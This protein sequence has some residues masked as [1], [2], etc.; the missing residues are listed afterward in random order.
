MAGRHGN[1]GVVSRILP[2][3]DMPHLPD[4]TPVDIILNPLGV[5]SRMNIGQIMETHLGVV[6]HDLELQLREPDFRRGDRIGNPDL[7]GADDAA[8]SPQALTEY[9]DED[10]ALPMPP[11]TNEIT[12]DQLVRD[13]RRLSLK[14]LE[15][16]AKDLNAQYREHLREA[17]RMVIADM[18][19]EH[20]FGQVTV[21]DVPLED[22]QDASEEQR[23]AWMADELH[24]RVNESSWIR[25]DN[26]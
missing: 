20:P 16:Y 24:M 9:M 13:I 1:K 19:E 26:G 21:R 11:L 25:R 5:P 7:F 15:Q 17:A 8:P 12:V 14:E 3:Q 6:A 4:G 18:D 23:I 10:L 22:W 2:A